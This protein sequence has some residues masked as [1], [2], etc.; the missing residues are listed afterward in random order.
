M[1]AGANKELLHLEK[2]PTIWECALDIT[3]KMMI[4]LQ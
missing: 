1:L 2:G 3:I 4:K